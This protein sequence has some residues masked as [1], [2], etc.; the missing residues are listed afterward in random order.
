MYTF[1]FK[2]TIEDYINFNM[3]HYYN[4]KSSHNTITLIRIIGTLIIILFPFIIKRTFDLM[5]FSIY[6]VMGILFFILFKKFFDKI[7]K[8]NVRKM[9]N[10]NSYGDFLLKRTLTI[11]DNEILDITDNNEMK[12]SWTGVTKIH[13]DGKYIFIYIGTAQA[14]IIPKHLFENTDKEYEFKKHLKKM[15]DNS[16]R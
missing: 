6:F 13:E 12:T 4:S 5:L 9:L 3:F 1:N 14:F 2:L 16:R 8:K 10:E 15:Y 7:L 11:T